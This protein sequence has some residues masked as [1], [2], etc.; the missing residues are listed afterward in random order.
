[1]GDGS[2]NLTG[3]A[4]DIT[5]RK[6]T[7]A[8]RELTREVLQILNAPVDF[9]NSIRQVLSVLKSRT[10]FAAVG[11]RLKNGDDFPYYAQDGFSGEF[12]S[13][14]IVHRLRRRQAE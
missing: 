2:G 1:M 9:R 6:Q 5:N 12:L 4:S 7:E 3:I 11:I 14:E 13:T 8:F 10:G